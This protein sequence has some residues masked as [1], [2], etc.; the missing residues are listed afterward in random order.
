MDT[1]SG[2]IL[3]RMPQLLNELRVASLQTPWCPSRKRWQLKDIP[4]KGVYVYYEGDTPLYVGRSDQVAVRIKSH[5]T[6]SRGSSDSATFAFIL[7]RD[8]WGIW[9]G[10]YW[11]GPFPKRT[12]EREKETLIKKGTSIKR[13]QLKRNTLLNDDDVFLDFK[14][15][16]ERVRRMG[17]RVIPIDDPYTQAMFEVYAAHR[18]RTYYNDFRNH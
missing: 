16:V 18:L 15:Q 14:C 7:T 12:E 1:S 17:V 13:V 2:A 5:G 3:R 8:L 10:P 4:G 9:K 6:G 11:D